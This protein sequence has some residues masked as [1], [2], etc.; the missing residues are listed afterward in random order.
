MILQSGLEQW[1]CT[2]VDLK[3]VPFA[4]LL[5]IIWRFSFRPS[6][7]PDTSG[8]IEDPQK[9]LTLRM[10][11]LVPVD[12]WNFNMEKSEVFLCFGHPKLGKWNPIMK[13]NFM[14]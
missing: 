2:Y 14:R 3:W 11:V 6:P 8:F 7:P 13:L 12:M 5:F 10:N 1:S 9:G 4:T